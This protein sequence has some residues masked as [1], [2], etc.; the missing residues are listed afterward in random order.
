[1]VFVMTAFTES[2]EDIRKFLAILALLVYF[3]DCAIAFKI[4]TESVSRPIQFIS[5]NVRLCVCNLMETVL[6]YGLDTFGFIAYC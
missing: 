2:P 3:P 5:C 4:F 6:P 1:M